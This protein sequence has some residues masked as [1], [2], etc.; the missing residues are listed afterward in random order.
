MQIPVPRIQFLQINALWRS[1]YI[2]SYQF[3]IFKYQHGSASLAKNKK[4]RALV[5]L[6]DD[7][8]KTNGLIAPTCR[9]ENVSASRTAERRDFRAPS[10]VHVRILVALRTAYGHKKTNRNGMRFHMAFQS[11]PKI[12][13]IQVKTTWSAT[14][15]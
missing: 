12:K 5:I 3:V 11:L 10:Y 9:F 4:S 1:D 6:I 2:L 15:F 13:K 8:T 7:T 14:K